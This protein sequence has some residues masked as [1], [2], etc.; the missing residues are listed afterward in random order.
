[1]MDRLAAS[2]VASTP[3]LSPHMRVAIAQ[4]SPVW[5]DRA[6]TV[7]KVAHWVERAAAAGAQ[8]VAF[9]EALVP[10]YPFW[11]EHTDGARFESGI[12]KTLFAHY[13]EQAVVL[14]RGDLDPVRDAARTHA[15]TV[16]IGTI[17]RAP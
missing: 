8:L 7:A 2:A 14:E 1:M 4:I 17:E 12:Q 16:V 10:G 9:G 6:Q 15:I 3:A 13:A 11:V 5:M